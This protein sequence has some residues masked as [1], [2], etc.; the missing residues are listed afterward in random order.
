M[1]RVFNSFDKDGNGKIDK[2]ELQA[3]F[4]EMGK[5]FPPKE[6]ERM[7]KIADKDNSGTLE[8]EEFIAHCFGKK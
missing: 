2:Y 3:A 6:I 7:I 5:H 1:R 4:K 8:Y